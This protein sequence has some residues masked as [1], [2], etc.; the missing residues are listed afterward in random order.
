[1]GR[2]CINQRL[3]PPIEVIRTPLLSLPTIVPRVLTGLIFYWLVPLV[4]GVIAWKAWAFPDMGH[5]LTFL[6]GVVTLVFVG[7]QLRRS[8]HQAVWLKRLSYFFLILFINQLVLASARLDYFNVRCSSS[9]QS[10]L[11]HG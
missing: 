10:F 3:I 9:V 11:M 6:S 1:M 7:L 4:I 5:P 2:Q 8:S